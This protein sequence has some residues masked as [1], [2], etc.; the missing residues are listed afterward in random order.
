[1]AVPAIPNL[2][3]ATTTATATV[4][5]KVQ[6][7]MYWYS[8]CCAGTISVPAHHNKTFMSLDIFYSPR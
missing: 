3:T 1:M 4:M 7:V 6:V 8:N 2:L 5:Y